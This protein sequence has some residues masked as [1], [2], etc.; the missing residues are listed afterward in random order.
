MNTLV[1]VLYSDELFPIT[2]NYKYILKPV[3]FLISI[4]TVILCLPTLIFI[5]FVPLLLAIMLCII[6]YSNVYKK[7]YG[8]K[9][10][11]YSIFTFINFL[12][13]FIVRPVVHNLVK[14]IIA[15]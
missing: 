12:T 4:T 2:I 1:R 8:N 10:T 3:A 13:F 15:I 5:V 6:S 9:I 14:E 11:Y 7:Y